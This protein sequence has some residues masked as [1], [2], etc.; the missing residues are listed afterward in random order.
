MVRRYLNLSGYICHAIHQHDQ[1]RNYYLSLI[2]LS[3]FDTN[4]EVDEKVN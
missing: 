4:E 2:S 1:G 3:L